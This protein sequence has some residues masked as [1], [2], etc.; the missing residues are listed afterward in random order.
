MHPEWLR[1]GWKSP[2]ETPRQSD[3]RLY[4]GSC[5]RTRRDSLDDMGDSTVKGPTDMVQ[6]GKE[7]DTLRFQ[8]PNAYREYLHTAVMLSKMKQDKKKADE[9]LA[10]DSKRRTALEELALVSRKS[11]DWQISDLFDHQIQPSTLSMDIRDI[12]RRLD[13]PLRRDLKRDALTPAPQDKP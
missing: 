13:G 6:W 8:Y 9:A 3:V 12:L 11:A 2:N 5:N 7:M 1:W 4:Y 10:K